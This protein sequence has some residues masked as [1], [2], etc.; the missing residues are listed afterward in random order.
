M[1]RLRYCYVALVFLLACAD[2]SSC[3]C[4][5]ETSV[6]N[7]DIVFVGSPVSSKYIDGDRPVVRYLFSVQKSTRK[8]GATVE[9]ETSTSDCGS[10]FEVGETYEVFADR[11]KDDVPRWYTGVCSGNKHLMGRVPD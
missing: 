2:A 5:S 6:R 1:K 9:I 3:V 11:A 7:A 8:V 4:V 10:V